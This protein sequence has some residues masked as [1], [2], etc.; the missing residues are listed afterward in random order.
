MR[1]KMEQR[2]YIILC[3][4]DSN[5]WS[6]ATTR[7]LVMLVRRRRFPSPTSDTDSEHHQLVAV[8]SCADCSRLSVSHLGGVLPLGGLTAA[9][10]RQWRPA[11]AMHHG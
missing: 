10:G 3:L 7:R 11:V 9:R 5:D 6:N 8:C 1:A 2:E 4:E